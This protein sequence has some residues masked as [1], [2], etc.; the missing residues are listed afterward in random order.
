[1]VVST[2][3]AFR[4][5]HDRYVT[6]TDELD[7]ATDIRT[8][9]K[10]IAKTQEIKDWEKFTLLCL[11]NDKVALKTYHGWY[12]TATDDFD[13]ATGIRTDWVLWA[14]TNE[15][16]AWEEFTLFDADT[17]DAGTGEPKLLSCQD[18]F[19]RLKRGEEARIA[20]QTYHKEGNQNR[21][22][23]AEESKDEKIGDKWEI[24]KSG[25]PAL[26]PEAKFTVIPQK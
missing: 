20:L 10:L 22:V 8:Y 2:T 13:E 18:L 26:R 23:V 11:A 17:F 21:Y 12:V 7:E 16:L 24:L 5:S 15:R 14:R 3:V 6:A 4:T 1:M 19:G 25:A 9:W